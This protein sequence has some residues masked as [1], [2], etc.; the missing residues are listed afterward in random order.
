MARAL[1][2]L[3]STIRG[4][5]GGTTYTSNQWHQI[6]IRQRT[7]PVQPDTNYQEEIRAAFA[8]ADSAWRIGVTDS[9]RQAW[10]CYAD[11]CWYSGPLGPYQIPGRQMFMSNISAGKYLHMRKTAYPE[12]T[13]A[14]PIIPGFLALDQLQVLPPH[15]AATGFSISL[16]NISGETVLAWIQRSCAFNTTRQRYK[17]P[18]LPTTLDIDEIA[19]NAT[20]EVY[21]EGLTAGMIYFVQ[22]RLISSSPP[23]RLSQMYT[24][25]AE[26]VLGT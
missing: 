26:A 7:A 18:F 23:I 21:F 24:L 8:G 17:G 6:V 3:H 10:K 5:I 13:F 22:L 1:S 9:V 4:S 25:R 20:G 11:T 14:A 19:N 12:P 2:I 15:A 16:R